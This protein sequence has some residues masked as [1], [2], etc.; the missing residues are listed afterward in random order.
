MAY[1]QGHT[2]LV[3]QSHESRNAENTCAFFLHLLRPHFRVLDAGCGPGT[4]TSSI[5]RLFSQGSAVG[6]DSSGTAIETAQCRSQLATNC[7]FKVALLENLPFADDSF[8][9][10]YTSQVLVHIPN[11]TKAFNEL[12]RVCKPGGFVACREGSI[13]E[14]MLF[15]PH[16]GLQAWKSAMITTSTDSGCHCTGGSQLVQWALRAGFAPEQIVYSV[17]AVSYSGSER[18]F[19]GQTQARRVMEDHI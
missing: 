17:G 1:T 13:A 10:V 14:T 3:Y 19:W 9:V 4:V 7:S 8:D 6:I 16:P 11:V 2:A 18:H 12:R 5:A 15:P